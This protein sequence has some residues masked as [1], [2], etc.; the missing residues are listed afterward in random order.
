MRQ[1][2]FSDIKWFNSNYNHLSDWLNEFIDSSLFNSVMHKFE[3]WDS[4][5]K[6]FL[7]NFNNYKS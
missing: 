6:P 3:V 7:I 5:K 1:F 2:A 4:N